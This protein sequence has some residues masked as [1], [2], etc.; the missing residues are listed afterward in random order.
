M[1]SILLMIKLWKS[2]EVNKYQ[3]GQN[4]SNQFLIILT[5]EGKKD[6]PIKSYD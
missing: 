3:K 2:Y 6:T 5:K 1:F 4:K